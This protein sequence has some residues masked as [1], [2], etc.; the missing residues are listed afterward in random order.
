VICSSLTKHPFVGSMSIHPSSGEKTET[1][2][3]DASAPMSL[4]RPGG[5]CVSR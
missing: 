2:Q 5:G 3:W 1:Q 4:G